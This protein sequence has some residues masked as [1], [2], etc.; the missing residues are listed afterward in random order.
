MTEKLKTTPT[1]A[2][3]ILAVVYFASIAAPLN[4]YKPPPIMPI[5]MQ[6]LHINLTEAGFLMSSIA[7]TGMI[8]ALPGGVILQKYGSKKSGLLA[9]GCLLVGT[10][11]GAIAQSFPLLA[12][13]RIIEGIGA[14]LIGVV[15]PATLAQ[16]FPADRL[17]VAM[18]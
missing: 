17:G 2:W 18:G 6:Q 8:L 10:I 12:F 15:A 5:L 14:G 11:L 13:S 16:W 3:I 1:Y 7:L 4:Q 9:L